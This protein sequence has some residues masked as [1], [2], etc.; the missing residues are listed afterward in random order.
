MHEREWVDR[1]LR[2]VGLVGFVVAAIG[3]VVFIWGSVSP[4][5]F[6][7]CNWAWGLRPFGLI[8]LVDGFCGG[9]V[10]MGLA[11]IIGLLRAIARK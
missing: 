7:C 5:W 4:G 1:L 11:E 6:R 9:L 3:L 8:L 10:F 2:L